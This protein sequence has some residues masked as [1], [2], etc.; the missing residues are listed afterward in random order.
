M[1]LDLS[2]VF[3]AAFAPLLVLVLAIVWDRRQRKRTGKP[4]Q[5]EKLLR[6]PGYSLSLRLDKTFDAVMDNILASCGFSTVAG[7][8]VVALGVLF[9]LRVPVLWLVI[10]ILVLAAFAMASAFVALKAFRGFKEAQNIRLGLSGE[11]AVAE[12]LNEAAEF[13]FRAFHDLQTDKV[14]NIDHV[15]VSTRGVFLI[16]TKARRKRGGNNRQ[17]AHEVLYDGEALQFPF[18]RDTEPI[19]QAKRNAA[20]L[21]NYLRNKT[22]EP[23][24][25]FPLVVLPGWFVKNSEK[26]NFRVNVMNANYLP[27]FL[28]R[29]D[30]KI[31]PAQVRR[32]I[33]ALDEK[34]RDVEF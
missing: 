30:E 26:G 28:Q 19:E 1:K 10:C 5:S 16:E 14:G 25:V 31:E 12:A 17:A 33:T 22:G 3:L 6:P 29:Q 24:E 21:S 13:G 18:F 8:C 34:C 9:S 7:F 20:W 11:Q 2:M 27:G 23:V 4:P 32:I 15:T